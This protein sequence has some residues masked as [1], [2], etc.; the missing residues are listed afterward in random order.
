MGFCYRETVILRRDYYP[1]RAI[2]FH[3]VAI[4]VDSFRESNVTIVW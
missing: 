1:I 3:L 4:T 2:E